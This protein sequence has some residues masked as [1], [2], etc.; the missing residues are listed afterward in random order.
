[1][2]RAEIITAAIIVS[3]STHHLLA[4]WSKGLRAR[5]NLSQQQPNCDGGQKNIEQ[6]EG[7]E[8]HN[9]SWY[10]RDRFSR[11]HYAINNPRLTADFGDDPAGLD[12][13][14]AQRR[15]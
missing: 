14:E 6:R 9:Q 7:N 8:R 11:P 1:M 5:C 12:S 10:G 13:D 3:S 15:G 2:I 4:H